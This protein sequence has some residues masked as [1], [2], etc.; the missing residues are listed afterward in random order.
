MG[1]LGKALNRGGADPF[2][3]AVISLQVG[4]AR[5]NIQIALAQRVI[6][7]IGDDGCIVL[8]IG[9][10]MGGNLTGQRVKLVGRL[11]AGQIGD[12]LSAA[13]LASASSN[14]PAAARASDVTFAPD[15]IRATSSRRASASSG[16]TRVTVAANSVVFD[17]FQ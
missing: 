17:T 13:H 9:G 7:G 8:I 14:L 1:Y 3:R 6:F 12:R 4:K 15:S 16:F 2:R 5:L 11:G 10:I